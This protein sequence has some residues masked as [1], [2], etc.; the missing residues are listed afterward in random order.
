MELDLLKTELRGDA[1]GALLVPVDILRKFYKIN[2][3]LIRSLIIIR[4][5]VK[6]C[7]HVGEDESLLQT[8]VFGF[9]P[10]TLRIARTLDS[11]TG[12]RVT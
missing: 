3:A 2:K 8:T 5:F 6:Q 11:N 1:I 12:L 9:V 10:L 4:L 7:A